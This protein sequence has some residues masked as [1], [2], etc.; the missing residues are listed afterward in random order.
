MIRQ[1]K[2]SCKVSFRDFK[3]NLKFVQNF[4]LM[5]HLPVDNGLP[6]NLTGFMVALYLFVEQNSKETVQ[7]QK[8]IDELFK[9][10]IEKGREYKELT[11][12][13]MEI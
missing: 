9:E 10:N 6:D 7:Q 13:R 12:K 2:R 3:R 5:T 8:E 11:T 1:Y 4:Y